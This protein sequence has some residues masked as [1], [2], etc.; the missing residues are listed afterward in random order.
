VSGR[1][2]SFTSI[3]ASRDYAQTNTCPASLS[4]R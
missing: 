4:S 2:V 1:P 3:T